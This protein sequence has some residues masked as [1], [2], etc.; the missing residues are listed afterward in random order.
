MNRLNIIE[1]VRYSFV[2]IYYQYRVFHFQCRKWNS[3]NE[4]VCGTKINIKP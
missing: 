4:G 2:K 3:N 1:T